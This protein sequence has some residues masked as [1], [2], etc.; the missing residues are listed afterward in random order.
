MFPT[1]RLYLDGLPGNVWQTL[2]CIWY[3]FSICWRDWHHLQSISSSNRSTSLFCFL[4]VK[5]RLCKNAINKNA[6]VRSCILKIRLIYIKKRRSGQS[7][8]TL[9]LPSIETEVWYCSNLSSVLVPGFLH[10]NP[11][12][13]S[14]VLYSLQNKICHISCKTQVTKYKTDRISAHWIV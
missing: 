11:M 6:Y 1:H 12:P 9:H 3:L 14:T 13:T 7:A 5:Q 10:W 4:T 8:L 2:F